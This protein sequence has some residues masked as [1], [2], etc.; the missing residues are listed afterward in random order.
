MTETTL[1]NPISLLRVC[2][3]A[4][5]QVDNTKLRGCATFKDTYALA[6][7]VE[8]HIKAS[9][10]AA[11]KDVTVFAPSPIAWELEICFFVMGV[12]DEDGCSTFVES[13][14]EGPTSFD[15]ILQLRFEDTGEIHPLIDATYTDADEASA[16]FD[17]LSALFPDA[18]HNIWPE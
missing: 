1:A 2:L 15:V 9:D 5:N 7:A 3:D 10:A 4:L 12:V 14:D 6:S 8:A 17:A 18:S 13:H 16:A 11:A